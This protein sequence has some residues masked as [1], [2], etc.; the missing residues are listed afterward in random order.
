V[1]GSSRLPALI[2]AGWLF[3]LPVSRA[4][5]EGE[6]PA[7]GRPP[8]VSGLTFQVAS[9]YQLSYEELNGLVTVRPGDPLTPEGV[10][11]SIRRLNAKSVFREVAVFVREEGGKAD[12]L[13]FL[14]PIP[15][16]AEIEVTGQKALTSSQIVSASRLKKGMDLGEKD[17]AAAEA[18]VREFLL[19][20]GFTEARCAIEVSCN[21]VNGSGKARIAVVE[22]APAAVRDLSVPGATHFPLE[23]IAGILGVEVGKPFDFRR[24]EEGLNRLRRE[25]KKAGFL[26]VR[27]DDSPSLCEEGGGLCLKASVEQGRRYDVRWEG[28]REFTPERLA[29]AAGL[30]E[31]DEVT[32]G[33]LLYDVRERL[34]AFYREK[35]YLRAEV[36]VS[37][38]EEAAGAVPLV[39]TVR[40]GKPGYVRSIRFEGNRGISSETL[41]RQM[42]TRARGTFHWVTGSGIFSEEEWSQDESALIGYYQKE[43]YVRMKI[44]GVDNAWDEEGGVI[45]IVRI[46]E[47]ARY[48]LRG[49]AF[50]GN[51]H[52]LRQELLALMRNREGEFV[53]YIGLERDQEAIAAKYRDSGFLDAAVEGTLAFDEGEDTVVARFAITEGVRYRLGT[54][55]VQGNLLTEALVVLREN[56]IRRGSFAGEAD[57]LKFQQSVY[58]TGLY[59]SVRLQRIRRPQDRLL[60]LVVEVEEAMFFDVEL[61]AGYGTETGIRGSVFA[62]ERNLDGLG[63]SL[64]GLALVGQKEQNFQLQ[65]REPY[66]LGNRWK[67][68]GVLTGSY[69]YQERPSFKLRKTALVAGINQKLQERSTVSLQ[70]QFSRDRTYEVQPG[71]VISPEDQGQAN[72]GSVA[73]L[74]VLDFRDDPFNPKRGMFVSA[75]AELANLLFG[76][77]VNYW[78]LTGQTGYYIPFARR[79]SLALSA[80]AGSI[81]PYGG[82][83]EVPI[84]KRFFAGGRTTVRG[85]DQDTLGPLGP[86]GA[87]IGGNFQL[88]LNAELRV[89][90]R[91][92]FL[93][94][95]F[96]DGGSV[97]LWKTPPYGFDFRETAGLGLRYITPVGPI[98]IDYGWKL[99]RKPGESPGAASFSVG[100]VF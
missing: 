67:W 42:T 71:A 33:A 63:R 2:L 92:G 78:S 86:D 97:W 88:I 15:Y 100:A 28:A 47:G 25:Y 18:A 87:P 21:T 93:A 8:V 22:G 68:E 73:G 43:G 69:L 11:E 70:Y 41:L 83:P 48:R 49:I 24:W 59:R 55:V 51:D 62:K 40:E 4:G 20:K 13:F 94:A 19:R 95:G 84:Q 12:L 26:T 1:A 10:R 81:L 44:A 57:L 27:I 98:S 50:A 80:R 35:Q 14:R 17:L 45:K 60:D 58:G 37:L 29:D 75:G 6:A 89:P 5:A 76:S 64:S 99:D 23:R 38:G 82:T 77:Q 36:A 53:D 54:V 34:A 66:A 7:S 61:A 96:V 72:I 39:V 9:P 56:P 52:F 65:L 31:A 79:N 46:E 91:Y 30:Y 74:A 3:L 85:F 90:L 16:L 32:E